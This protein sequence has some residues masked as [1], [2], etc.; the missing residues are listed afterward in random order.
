MNDDILDKQSYVS[1]ASLHYLLQELIPM[2]IRVSHKLSDP[3]TTSKLAIE[4]QDTQ[5]NDGHHPNTQPDKP[6]STIPND[7]PGT[8]SILAHP[9]L[10]QD[11]ITIRIENYGYQIGLK[12]ANVLLYKMT[13]SKLIVDVLDVMKFVCRDVW[14][15]M[16]NKQMDNLRTNH[17]GTFVLVDNNYRLI[18]QL[19]SPKGM[20]DTLNKSK[21]YLW[22]PCG[23]IRGIL[24]SFGVDANVSAE[25]TQF[26][27]VTFNIHTTINN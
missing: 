9:S 5:D 4:S 10:Q 14:V 19:N 3:T 15:C 17:R 2:T 26:P 20:Q 27:S 8:I 18:N 22:F 13:N 11:E 7:F 12:I 24:A 6:L 25:I 16:Y 23:V 1:N 21:V